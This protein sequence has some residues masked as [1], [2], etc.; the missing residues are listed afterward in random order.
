MKTLT[1]LI[2]CN[3]FTLFTLYAQC[4]TGNVQLKNQ[5]EIDAFAA[6]Y[7]NCTVINGALYIGADSYYDSYD[8]QISDLSVMPPIEHITG[9]LSIIYT[10]GWWSM[11]DNFDQLKTIGGSLNI[12]YNW[13]LSDIDDFPQLES[14]GGQLNFSGQFYDFREFRG[15]ERLKRIGGSLIVGNNA[16]SSIPDFDSLTFVRSISIT[17]LGEGLSA[18]N[19]FN[20]LPYVPGNINL[21]VAS[22]TSIAGFSALERIGGTLNL[23]DNGAASFSVNIN[24]F[25]QLRKIGGS[26][27]LEE[28]Q[29]TLNAFAALDT[30]GGSLS[31]KAHQNF[32]LNLSSFDHAIHIGGNLTISNNFISDCAVQAVCDHLSVGGNAVIELNGAGCQSVEEVTTACQPFLPVEM[33]TPLSIHLNNTTAILQWRTATETNNAGFEIQ[34]SRDGTEWERI[35]WQ[36][37]QGTVTTPYTYSYTDQNPLFGTSYYRLKQVDFNGDTEYSNVVSLQ[38]IRNGV[39]VYPNPV[40]EQLYLQTDYDTIQQIVIYDSTGRQITQIINPE[41]SIDVSAFLEG[42]Y[43]IKMTLDGGDFYEKIIVK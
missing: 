41:R 2:L 23:E 15:L 8:A 29:A 34:R 14:I 5:A 43:M 3:F 21:H 40:N 13:G 4:P 16:T 32:S 10:T 1:V 27:T 35:G 26:L 6:Q 11:Y 42:V 9:G 33:T 28:N 20:Q 18:V 37:G 39:S 31:I 25:N 19:G 36:A 24:A 17:D 7:P 12:L 22:A 38:Y 30:I